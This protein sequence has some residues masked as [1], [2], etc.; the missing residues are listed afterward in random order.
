MANLR[1]HGKKKICKSHNNFHKYFTEKVNLF[2]NGAGDDK[3]VTAGGPSVRQTHG[4]SGT[5]D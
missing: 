4:E 5:Q 3:F 1:K 2:I